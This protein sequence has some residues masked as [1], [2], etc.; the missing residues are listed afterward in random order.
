MCSDRPMLGAYLYHTDDEWEYRLRLD[1]PAW[2]TVVTHL[3]DWLRAQRKYEDKETLSVVEVEERL[4]ALLDD[5][6]LRVD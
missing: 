6:G 4:R 1:G 3:A 5:E 2:M